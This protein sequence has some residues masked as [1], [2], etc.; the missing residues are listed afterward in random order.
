[1][2]ASVDSPEPCQACGIRSDLAILDGQNYV[3]SVITSEIGWRT[4]LGLQNN[5]VSAISRPV[6]ARSDCICIRTGQA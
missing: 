4:P 2:L 6:I 5:K 1:M 3:L